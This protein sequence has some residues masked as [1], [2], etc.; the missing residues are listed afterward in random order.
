MLVYKYRS[1]SVLN[2]GTLYSNEIY[3]SKFI[4]LND[5]FEGDFNENI[6]VFFKFFDKIGY[7]TTDLKESFDEFLAYS[8]KIGI[9]SL[10]ETNKSELLWGH[11]AEGGRG[12]CL[13]YDYDLLTKKYPLAEKMNVR[14]S[15]KIPSLNTKEFL[16]GDR[17]ETYTKLFGIKSKAWFYE[18]EKRLIFNEPGLKIYPEPALKEIYLGCSSNKELE[19]QIISFAK[20]KNIKVYKQYRDD[21]K[22]LY[23]FDLI[24]TGLKQYEFPLENNSFELM[25]TNHNSNVENFYVYYYGDTSADAIE[26]F[27]YAF[28]ERFS[29]IFC[30]IYLFKEKIERRIILKYP[31]SSKEYV[32]FAESCIALSGFEIEKGFEKYPFKDYQYKEYKSLGL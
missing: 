1:N 23:K 5:P 7:D 17:L 26:S 32:E 29:I 24:F 8:N 4:D 28:K 13:G 9:Y 31:K 11:Y 19:T 18:Q 20:N 21:K 10:S 16:N 12:F 14:Y 3:A 6:A 27:M 22:Y 30:N 15:E 2:L 25:F